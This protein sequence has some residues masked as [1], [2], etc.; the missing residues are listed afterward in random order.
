MPRR[1]RGGPRR[2]SRAALRD[3]VRPAPQRAPVARSRVPGGRAPESLSPRGAPMPQFQDLGP[4][5]GLIEEMYRLYVENP[6]A[7]VSYTHLRAHE[8]D[9]YLVC[10]LL[11]EKKK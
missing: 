6:A 8:T 10:R 2:P 3:H 9:S 7:A 1:Y 11:L 5:S 4:N